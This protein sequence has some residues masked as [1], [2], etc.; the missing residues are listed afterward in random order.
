M[1]RRDFVRTALIGGGAALTLAL[2]AASAAL[3]PN[4]DRPLRSRLARLDTGSGIARWQPLEQCSSEACAAP[5]RMRFSI[6][7]LQFP[8]AF[9]AVVIDAMFA[10]AQGLRPFR[11]A[12][13]QPDSLSPT[14]KPFSFDVDSAT[15][16]GFRCEHRGSAPGTVAIASAA[17]LG[18]NRP[19]LAA[20]RYLLVVSDQDRAIDIGSFPV[21]TDSM[22]GHADGHVA[23]FAWL[24]F[25]VHRLPA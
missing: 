6:D 20:G 22:P 21:T 5:E 19:V 10:T 16:V 11:M 7:A 1:Q 12:S 15:L 2:P 17:L 23:Q 25:S 24:A 18:D 8:S 3:R 13:H 9:R 4:V 14:S